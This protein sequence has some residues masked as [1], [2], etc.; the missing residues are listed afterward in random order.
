MKRLWLV[1]VL[2]GCVE[3][4]ENRSSLDEARER[5]DSA[6]LDNYVY[7]FANQ[8][9]CDGPYEFTV[10]VINGE[11]DQ[12]DYEPSEYDSQEAIDAAG[13]TIEDWF[14]EIEEALAANPDD[15]S[16]AYDGEFGYPTDISVDYDRGMADE[17]W[18]STLSAFE[19]I[20]V[21]E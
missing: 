8:C 7:T 2:A 6:G 19:V 4:A 17:E 3:Q 15:T 18:N 9:E 11:V 14:S 1:A 20:N 16:I 12:V 5:W 10:T 21:E 13:K